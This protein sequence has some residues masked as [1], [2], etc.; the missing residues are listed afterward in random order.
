[1]QRSDSAVSD[2]IFEIV[3]DNPPVNAGTQA[4]RAFVLE[5]LQDAAKSAAQAV[6]IRGKG[7]N[8]VAG[9]DL[10]EFSGPLAAPQ[11]PEVF[12]AIAALPMPVIAAIEGAALGGGYELALACDGRIAD[13]GAI[14]GLPE[15][16]LGIVPGAGGTQR[17]PRLTGRSEA[18]RLICGA[19][20]VPAEEALRLGMIDRL[21]SEDLLSE[22]KDFALS[23][24]G[25]QP[26]DAKPVPE[27]PDQQIEE[28]SALALK[29][30]RGN[31]VVREAIA[32]IR[33]A[34]QGDVTESLAREREIFQTLRAGDE[35]AALRYQFFAERT[36]AKSLPKANRAARL[37]RVGVL[38]AGTMG[39][40]LT[41]SLL[42]AGKSV[43][44]VDIA[45]TALEKGRETAV[46]ALNRLL[47]PDD[48]AEAMARLRTSSALGALSQCEMVI[49]AVI[50]DAGV[51]TAVLQQLGTA[52]SPSAVLA[53]NT[54]Y[55]DIATLAKASGRPDRFLGL[56][57][58]AP[59]P[60]MALVEIVPLP[61]TLPEV[62]ATAA[63]LVRDM[64]KIAVKAGPCEGFLGNRIYAAYRAQC[65]FL[66][67]EGAM[68][69][70]V[71][72]VLRAQGFRMGVFQVGDLSG[73]DIGWAL[74]RKRDATRDPAERYVDMPDTLYDMG[75]LGRKTDAGW[76]L[77]NADYP[78]GA[79]DPEIEALIRARRRAGQS[80]P[81]AETI[82]RRAM[83]A[84]LN[85][86]AL[87]FADGTASAASDIDVVL[88]NGYGFA[89]D[90]GGPLWQAARL[91][92]TER[93]AMI[94]AVAVANGPTF[95]RGPVEDLIAA[96][97]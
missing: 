50:E 64:G 17:L 73:L 28:A 37:S 22:A 51:K 36:A 84:I 70:D 45:E 31:R 96:L 72:A 3:I 2:G 75:R 8:F 78:H 1:M 88:V 41:A 93:T 89:R 66:V 81:D 11:W 33:S 10:R 52:L 94:D 47:A 85:E 14:V 34:G 19:V 79:P 86:A 39:A 27:E 80:V 62:C 77:Y 25:K 92:A 61:E 97:Y 5:A 38:G 16:A 35:A 56:H 82:R 60:Q 30:A 7:G 76:Y 18:I 53:S 13:P 42:A 4:V 21:A 65:E 9:S 26:L 59:V 90:K 95:R 23:L 74:R 46:A 87:A 12:A 91:C 20:R 40:G 43:T 69:W 68:P 29:K 58:F 67:D 83:G 32:L 48:M 6:V 71:D 15:V 54:S 24:P 55:L 49:E 57:F 63:R 44:L